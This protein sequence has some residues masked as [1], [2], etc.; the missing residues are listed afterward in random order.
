MLRLIYLIR[1]TPLEWESIK[2]PVLEGCGGIS[3]W[4]LLPLILLL[5]PHLSQYFRS[6]AGY[7][8][9]VRYMTLPISA[10]WLLQP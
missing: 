3:Q 5:G 8:Q 10:P 1:I 7:C 2:L 4:F 9:E 6:Q